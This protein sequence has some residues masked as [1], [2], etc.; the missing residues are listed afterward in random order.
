[1]RVNPS[2]CCFAVAMSSSFLAATA[3][4]EAA[5]TNESAHIN[6]TNVTIP[7]VAA[8]CKTTKELKQWRDKQKK[9]LQASVPKEFQSYSISAI[10]Q[11]YQ[12][13]L[14]KLEKG[15]N[16]GGGDAATPE[17]AKDC[18]T[19]AE[20]KRWRQSQESLLKANVPVFVQPAALAPIEHAYRSRLAE[21]ENGANS[22]DSSS[23]G[24]EASSFFVADDS[25]EAASAAPSASAPAPV[26]PASNDYQQYMDYSKYMKGG[27]SHSSSS[28]NNNS[29]DKKSGDYQKYMDYSKY[30]KGGDG[31]GNSNGGGGF[32]QYMDYS[33]YMQSSDSNTNSGA[34]SSNFVVFGS[35]VEKPAASFSAT[36]AAIAA[37]SPA[38]Q[39]GVSPS[40][41]RS[42]AN[43]QAFMDYRK[44][45]D[46]EQQ[47]NR[48]SVPV[49]ASSCKT[50]KELNAWRDGMKN[51]TKSL[52][53]ASFRKYAEIPIDQEYKHHLARLRNTTVAD[54]PRGEEPKDLVDVSKSEE[55]KMHSNSS[56]HPAS[57]A[58][59]KTKAELKQWKH[60]QE[61]LVNA[62]VPDFV[63]SLVLS[64][65][66]KE[67]T[68]RLERLE[69]K[70]KQEKEKEK[71]EQAAAKAA[72][73]N[74][75]AKATNDSDS[76]SKSK[77]DSDSN[78]RSKS[79][80]TNTDADEHKHKQSGGKQEEGKTNDDTSERATNEEA[81]RKRSDNNKAEKKGADVHEEEE[82]ETARHKAA[83]GDAAVE[84]SKSD[85]SNSES[86]K[87]AKTDDANHEVREAK[88]GKNDKEDKKSNNDSE[89]PKH[90]NTTATSQLAE[91]Q[92]QEQSLFQVGASLA[93]AGGLAAIAL[94]SFV[95]VYTRRSHDVKFTDEDAVSDA[96]FLRL[97]AVA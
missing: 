2:L 40:A 3:V 78:S 92:E 70:Q 43:F 58:D 12:Q 31:Q 20:L 39:S 60:S 68:A 23:R 72:K 89:A 53:P 51:S 48:S 95:Q 35:S 97:D 55:K 9:K 27:N 45:M 54:L 87:S 44:Y 61:T 7:A 6:S 8:D 41:A 47:A 62:T 76:D 85:S 94:L 80:G 11:E 28:S 50:E 37:S 71:Q 46:W 84:S 49:A 33:K 15:G 88:H 10:D 96:P 29:N 26:A 1:M 32:Q 57:A 79:K 90:Q 13:Q 30:M 21:L 36:A 65:I 63:Q 5:V 66:N 16:G 64:D 75:P 42:A 67:Y 93:I 38:Y 83:A 86:Q 34:A 56:V 74:K 18:K 91:E 17:R 77:S 4:A 52:V 59:C 19:P 25:S 69:A 73:N 22:T 81:Q 24:S 82:E 14:A